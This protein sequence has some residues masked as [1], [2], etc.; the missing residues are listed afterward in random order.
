M[1]RVI[2][3]PAVSNR[4]LH[5]KYE[6]GQATGGCYYLR[7]HQ[8][9][10]YEQQRASLANYSMDN[11]GSEITGAFCQHSD[12]SYCTSSPIITYLTDYKV[13]DAADALL[14]V[15][16]I[17]FVPSIHS[18]Q[19]IPTYEST[20]LRVFLYNVSGNSVGTLDD[21]TVDPSHLVEFPFSPSFTVEW[22][23][24]WLGDNTAGTSLQGL[25]LL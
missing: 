3:L 1:S 15:Q 2:D 24:V 17:V 14:N 4:Y 16:G 6:C 5:I 11:P 9:A 19:T 21:I 7:L 23:R 25:F 13:S 22:L 12:P 8:I 18:G 20:N 10:C